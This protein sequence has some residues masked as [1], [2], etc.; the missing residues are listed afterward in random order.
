MKKFFKTIVAI[1]A[2][3][4]MV[5]SSTT[6]SAVA[7]DGLVN[8][9]MVHMTNGNNLE[10][11]ENFWINVNPNEAMVTIGEQ[12]IYASEHIFGAD[13]FID[14]LFQFDREF[15]DIFTISKEYI[16]FGGL[17]TRS[18]A[19]RAGNHTSVTVTGT[20]SQA[21]HGGWGGWPGGFC[22]VVTTTNWVC[23]ACNTVG[24]EQRFGQIFCVQC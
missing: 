8:G 18:S 11:F 1:S 6:S 19:C 21:S 20:S 2:V 12:R 7:S 17:I 10:L 14:N 15:V 9:D 5:V 13:K 23:F 22:T 24:S 4:I 16:G 3:V